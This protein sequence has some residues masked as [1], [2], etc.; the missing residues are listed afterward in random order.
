MDAKELYGPK[1]R[2][3][4][5]YLLAD[6]QS[7]FNYEAERDNPLYK[8]VG[9]YRSGNWYIA[10]DNLGSEILVEQ[11]ELFLDAYKWVRYEI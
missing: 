5:R 7:E 1:A 2:E 3:V 8:C 11:F 9:V 4:C 6:T 10:F